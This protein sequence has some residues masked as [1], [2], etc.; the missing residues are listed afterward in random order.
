MAMQFYA[1][2][3]QIMRD[4]SELARKGIARGRSAVVLSYA[5]G[6]LFVAENLSSTL[7][8]VSEIYDRIGFAAVG[9]YNEFEN[10]RRAGVRMADLNGLSY[11]RR[12]V[13][14]LA[15]ANAYAQTLGAIFTEQSKPFEVEICVAEVG[16]TPE[17]DSL[18]RV[19]YD[20]SVNDEP[21]RMAMGGQ[22]EAISGVLKN[23]H[24]PEM[25]LSEA[26]RAAMKALSSVGGEGGA[27]RTIAANQLEVAVLDRRRVGR[28]FRRVTGAALTALL[29][30][31][32]EADTAPAPGRAKTPTVPTEEAK[33]PTTS[34]GSA[35]LEG[36][37][38]D[39][40]AE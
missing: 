34:A 14:G 15:L 29:D 32:A 33:K 36:N 37:A 5:G 18:Y 10:L 9:R 25:S 8:K 7:H 2:P 12:D 38:E 17:D 3:E 27:A 40:P 4:R 19:T 35:D 13:T 24:R 26:V 31:D 21:G 6:V 39:K 20:G 1:S 11:D 16:A 22:A 28:T 30:G 23:E